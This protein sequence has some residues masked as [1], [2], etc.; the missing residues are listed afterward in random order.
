MKNWLNFGTNLDFLRWVNE[1]K[2][3]TVVKAWPDFIAGNDPEAL[4]L[5]LHHQGLTFINAHIVKLL[6]TWLIEAEGN[7]GVMICFPNEV[8]HI[9]SGW[10]G[11]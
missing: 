10:I 1:Q 3:T 5:A 11:T 2:N 6:Q 9:T 8:L 4:G 7:M